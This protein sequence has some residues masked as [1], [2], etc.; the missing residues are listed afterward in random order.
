MQSKSVRSS[1]K[2][3]VKKFIFGATFLAPALSFAGLSIA[4]VSSGNTALSN[5]DSSATA[6]YPITSTNVDTGDSTVPPTVPTVT[7]TTDSTGANALRF[8]I[9][10]GST[11]YT[12]PTGSTATYSTYIMAFVNSTINT[13]NYY[14]IPIGFYN[15]NPNAAGYYQSCNPNCVLTG[16]GYAVNP[17]STYYYAVP[18]AAKSTVQIGIYPSDICYLYAGTQFNTSGTGAQCSGAASAG[19][20]TFNTSLGATETAGFQIKFLIVQIPTTFTTFAPQTSYI[21]DSST[22]LS[23]ISFTTDTTKLLLSFQNEGGSFS[24]CPSQTNLYFPGDKSIYLDTS[25]FQTKFSAP[26]LSGTGRTAPLNSALMTYTTSGSAGAVSPA[27]P[28][29]GTLTDPVL[30]RDI[31]LGDSSQF[32]QGFTN[33]TSTDSVYYNLKI[34]LRD[35]AG[36]ATT[37]YCPLNNVRTSEIQGFLK[38]SKCFIATAAFRSGTAAPVMMLRKFRDEVLLHFDAGSAFVDWYY[39][40]SPPAAEWLID[41]PGFRYPV[42]LALVP[43]EIFAWLCLRPL[44]FLLFVGAGIA[45]FFFFKKRWI[46]M[47]RGESL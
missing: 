6:Y 35:N 9:T 1:S 7:Q 43:I 30:T 37:N 38:D 5:T 26:A 27:T 12:A 28:T 21:T 39:R 4:P 29:A 44:I 8:N 16:T 36:Y 34:F 31:P 18:Y 45:F 32:V 41:H 24:S 47:P 14:P 3:W 22:T 20:G 17:A 40:W 25:Q 23:D 11:S 42:L 33:S 2:T 15:S 46:E 10:A 13:S 19:T